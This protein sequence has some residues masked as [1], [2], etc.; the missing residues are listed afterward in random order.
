MELRQEQRITK[1]QFDTLVSEIRAIV[2]D[3][4]KNHRDGDSERFLFKR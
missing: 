3:K 4:L 2:G 1:Q